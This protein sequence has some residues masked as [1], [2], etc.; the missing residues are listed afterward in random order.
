LHSGDADVSG[1]LGCESVSLCEWFQTFRKIVVFSKRLEIAVQQQSFT[2]Q[3]RG[4]AIAP[5]LGINYATIR[6]YLV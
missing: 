6:M 1:L 3:K 5:H 4:L 2:P